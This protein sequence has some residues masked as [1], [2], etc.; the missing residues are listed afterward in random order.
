MSMNSEA[1]LSS[2]AATAV[3]SVGVW[4]YATK[5]PLAHA[6]IGVD[7]SLS[8]ERN[9]GGVRS[10]AKALLKKN[11]IREGSTLT[12]LAMGKS[13]SDPEPQPLF[14]QRIP[15]EGDSVYSRP[16]QERAYRETVDALLADVEG[17][18]AEIDDRRHT[19]LYRLVRQGLTQL[20][21]GEETCPPEGRCFFVVKSDLIEDVHP[22][23]TDLLARA[24]TDPTTPVPPE[25][26]GSLDNSGIEV[27]FAGIAELR[28][29]K[30]A[31]RVALP[32]T[33]E[34]IWRE[35][36]AHPELVA[37]QPFAVAS[38]PSD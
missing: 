18:C 17:A 31:A 7:S 10:V 13:P 23:L 20:R 38:D 15:I 28:P 5:P 35:L 1:I 21:S 30:N 33:R 36:F 26:A 29:V 27:L 24:A 25:I 16:E 2:C 3:L 19:P 12:F 14:S 34:R 9:C 37:F 32:E 22:A 8:V 6:A 11:G 4:H